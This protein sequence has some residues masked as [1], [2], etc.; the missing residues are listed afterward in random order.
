MN[1]TTN[2]TIVSTFFKTP[3]TSFI[4]L[5]AGALNSKLI[6]NITN[7]ERVFSTAYK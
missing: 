7:A 6:V 4:R 2:R 5:F 1:I 3:I